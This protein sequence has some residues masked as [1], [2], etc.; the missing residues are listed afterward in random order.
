MDMPKVAIVAALEREVLPLVRHWRITKREHSGRT[1]RFFENGEIVVVCGGIG[2]EAA[3]R[4]T[5]AVIVLYAPGL[6][7]SVGFAGALE[8]GL[9]VGE[10]IVP[11]RVVNAADGSSVETGAGEG[12]LV[13]FNSVASP[14]QKAKLGASFGA[15]AVDMEAAAVAQAAQA[16]SVRFGA[17]KAISDESN[18]P[19]PPMHNFIAPGGEFRTWRFAFFVLVRPWMYKT[20]LTLAHNTSRASHA[21]CSRLGQMNENLISAAETG[22]R[23]D[24]VEISNP[25]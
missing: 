17:V 25:R 23:A 5:E 2:T 14:E 8:P 18:F 22:R 3:R 11:R 10:I 13:S 15:Q 21:L 20:M 6:V 4:A 7:Y 19:L 16:R 9:K 1:F 12:V 24:S